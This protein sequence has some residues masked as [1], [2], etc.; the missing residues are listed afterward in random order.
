MYL[1]LELTPVT[2]SG[3][4]NIWWTN[5]IGHALIKTIDVKIGG[6]TIDKHYGEWLDIWDELIID[7]DHR[8]SY[9]KMVGN[10]NSSS[11][12]KHNNTTTNRFY[13]PMQLVVCRNPV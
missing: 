3:S 6:S 12:L 5:G 13:V 8:V 2:R 11:G 7:Q 10:F 9:D 4:G 1:E